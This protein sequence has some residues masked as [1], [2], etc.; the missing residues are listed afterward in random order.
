MEDDNLSQISWN[1]GLMPCAV[2]NL[3][4]V[5]GANDK[6]WNHQWTMW[7][8]APILIWKEDTRFGPQVPFKLQE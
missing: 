5:I 7:A 2:I 6:A 1:H 4:Y 3:M 8:H